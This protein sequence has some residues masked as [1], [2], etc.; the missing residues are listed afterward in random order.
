[1]YIV[2]AA[3]VIYCISL[4]INLLYTFPILGSFLRTIKTESDKLKTSAT[5]I[6][7]SFLIWNLIYIGQIGFIVVQSIKYFYITPPIQIYL[8]ALLAILNALWVIVFSLEM[9][10]FS[11]T[12]ICGMLATVFYQYQILEITY[13]D[14]SVGFFFSTAAPH[15]IYLGWISLACILNIFSFMKFTLKGLDEEAR[16]LSEHR[17]LYCF[18]NVLGVI[19]MLMI[20]IKQ[21]YVYL[22]TVCWGILGIY[23]N[24]NF[25]N[26]HFSIGCIIYSIFVIIGIFFNILI[27]NKTFA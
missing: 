8:F 16:V 3:I 9:V 22:V 19:T 21:D 13:Y 18:L 25:G 26:A 12:I 24:G 17:L 10:M 11:V 20:I 23:L 14:I 7:Y 5:P 1:M 6:G 2:I 27:F 15:S 4:L